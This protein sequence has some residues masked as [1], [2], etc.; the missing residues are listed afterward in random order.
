M[1]ARLIIENGKCVGVECTDGS[2]YRDDQAVLSTMHIKHLVDM[3]PRDLWP[4]EFLYGADTWE[5]EISEVVTHYAISEPPKYPIKGGTIS[6][7]ESAIL[8]NPERLLRFAYEN[9]SGISTI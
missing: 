1:V 9:E 2:C 3:A 5:G 8:A 7:V 6:R 4:A